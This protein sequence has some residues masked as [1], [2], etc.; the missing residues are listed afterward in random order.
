MATSGWSTYQLRRQ[1]FSTGEDFWIHNAQGENVYK[2][3]GK[4]LVLTQTFSLQDVNGNEVARMQAEML[5]L[6]KTMDIERSGQ[7]VATVKKAFF[8]V[9]SQSFS[10]EVAGDGELQAQGDI[11]NH[12]FQITAGGQVVATIS[13]QGFAA[14]FMYGIAIAP[15][16]DEVL[17]LCIAISIDEMSERDRR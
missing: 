6:R 5:T 15:G 1:L 9:L 4:V 13:K 12:E 10:A 11:L 16:Q 17:L 2:L 8:N 7:V 3:D 14:D